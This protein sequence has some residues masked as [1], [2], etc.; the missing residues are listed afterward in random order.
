MAHHWSDNVLTTAFTP[1]DYQVELLAAAREK[2][3]IICLGH[4]SSKEFIALKLIHELGIELRRTHHHKNTIFNPKVTL[5]LSSDRGQSETTYNLVYH[6][7]DLKVVN[8]NVGS[9]DI[10]WDTVTTDYQVIILNLET[11]LNALVCT[12]ID[13]NDVNLMVVEDCHK[14]YGKSEIDEIFG[15]YY[16]KSTTKPRILGLAGPLHN[17][18]CPPGRLGAELEF[19]EK[20][21][22]SRAETASDIVTV[23]RYCSKPIEVILQ[24][25]PPSQN[26]VSTFLRNLVLTKKL[27]I[28]EHRFDPSEIYEGFQD[29]INGKNCRSSILLNFG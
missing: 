9:I 3:I 4:N 20:S 1:R 23:L 2:N 6:L 19:L 27:F 16:A 26:E 22:Y 25:A 14:N 5:Y 21:L 11:C 7:T 18:G 10:E 13:L 28:K 15:V 24:C 17:A 8:L 29:E 12:Y